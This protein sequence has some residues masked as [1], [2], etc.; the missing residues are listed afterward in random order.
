[1]I[2]KILDFFKD[3]QDTDPAFIR[4][5]RNILLSVMVILAALLPLVTGL[6]GE[7][8]RNRLR[9]SQFQLRSYFWAFPC[10]MSG[11]ENFSWQK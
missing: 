6:T 2:A 11:A 10:F 4:M 3:E 1:M 7:T 8:A 9:S 5:T